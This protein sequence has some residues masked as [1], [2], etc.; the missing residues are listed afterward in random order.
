MQLNIKTIT[1]SLNKFLVEETDQV[2]YLKQLIQ[3]KI[4]LSIAQQHLVINGRILP[5]DRTLVDVHLKNG[6]TI[7]L[8]LMLKGGTCYS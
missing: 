8:M 5:D 6:D 2:S 1:G 3:E 7:Q 4:G